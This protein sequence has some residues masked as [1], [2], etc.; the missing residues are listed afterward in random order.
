MILN[1]VF[2][3]ILDTIQYMKT[4]LLRFEKFSN[5]KLLSFIILNIYMLVN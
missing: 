5:L 3:F 1:I 2:F 4:Y